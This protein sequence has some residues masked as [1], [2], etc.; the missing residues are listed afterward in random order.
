MWGTNKKESVNRVRFQHRSFKTKLTENRNYK[1]QQ[2]KLPQTDWGVFLKKIGLETIFSKVATVLVLVTL[3]YFSFVPN[4]FFI[5]QIIVQNENGNTNPDIEILTNLYLKKFNPWPQKNLAFLSKNKL[6]N[7]LT[8]NNKTILSVNV[9]KKDFPNTVYISYKERKDEFVIKT[10]NNNNYLVSED[11]KVTQEF[12]LN[13]SSSLPSSLILIKLEQD[14]NLP[15]WQNPFSH[16][17]FW[18]IR[19][20]NLNLNNK[21][22]SPVKEITIENLK[23]PFFNVITQSGYEIKFDASANL[24]KT[25][26]RLELLI[27]DLQPAL[28]KNLQYVDMRFNDRAYVCYKNNPCSYEPILINSSS[29]TTTIINN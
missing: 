6:L 28:V 7:Y 17:W 26:N 9:I 27:K 11:G 19:G 12:T 3:I 20:V 8:E 22:N 2:K 10:S 21:I 18:F 23:N 5:K 25:L 29:T 15:L 16:N 14:M 13:A 4:L 1:R 24:D